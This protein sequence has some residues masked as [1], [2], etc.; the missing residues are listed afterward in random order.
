MHL[1]ALHEALPVFM[2]SP[3]CFLGSEGMGVEM[4][5]QPPRRTQTRKGSIWN[6]ALSAPSGGG[7]NGAE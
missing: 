3:V 1:Q 5:S 6:L 2:Y 4:K 7:R